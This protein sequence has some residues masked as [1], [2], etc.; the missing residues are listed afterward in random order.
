M[1]IA[2][3]VELVLVLTDSWKTSSALSMVTSSDWKISAAWSDTLRLLG[4][5]SCKSALLIHPLE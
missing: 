2:S 3:L 4:K 5:I 1:V